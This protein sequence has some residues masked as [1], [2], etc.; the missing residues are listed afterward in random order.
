MLVM[1]VNGDFFFHGQSDGKVAEK[2]CHVRALWIL[3]KVQLERQLELIGRE[4]NT[5]FVNVRVSMRTR[6]EG[7]DN[8]I[9]IGEATAVRFTKI[10]I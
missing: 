2:F 1:E 5:L 3:K 6:S 8:D 9:E 7:P 10:R 4:K